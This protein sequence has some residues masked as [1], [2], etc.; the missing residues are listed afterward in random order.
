VKRGATTLGLTLASAAIAAAAAQAPPPGAAVDPSSFAYS[1]AVA[2]G[3]AAL[4]VLPLDVGAL[5]HSRGPLGRFAD[6]RVVDDENRQV[7]YLLDEASEPLELPISIG[8][9]QATSAQRQSSEGH[10]RS[11]YLVMLPFLRLPEAD[12]VVEPSAQTF[13][14]EVQLWEQGPGD[15]RPRE[16]WTA[17]IATRVWQHNDQSLAAPPLVLPARDRDTRFLY[18][19]IDEGDNAPLPLTSARLRLPAWRLRFYRPE[20]RPMR[21]LYG[22]RDAETPKYDL[23]LVRAEVMREPAVEISVGPEPPQKETAAIVSPPVFWGF[24]IAA[25]VVLIALI[26]RLA[27]S[28]SSEGLPPP[29]AP[30]P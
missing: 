17:T 25:V 10:H 21:L 24:L 6:V 20:G 8:P 19:T 1:R 11:T 28:R 15:R 18:L 9:V 16:P 26:A 5:C 14:R 22:N 13:R 23:A 4:V 2:P 3:P 30:R 29:S 27:T 12:L 7:P